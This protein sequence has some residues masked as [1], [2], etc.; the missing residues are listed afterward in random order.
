MIITET[1]HW[2]PFADSDVTTSSV[3][4]WDS[5]RPLEL[6]FEF[7]EMSPP[8]EWTFGRDLIAD[9]FNN[10]GVVAGQADVQVIVTLGTLMLSLT[11]PFG[12]ATLRTGTD[13]LEALIR[14]TYEEVP[15]GEAEATAVLPALDAVLA[16][17]LA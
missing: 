14:R 4:T 8:V 17:I 9:A 13:K 5:A 1:V 10:M 15:T 16:Q 6:K 7:P 3:V 11:S 12:T 2:Y